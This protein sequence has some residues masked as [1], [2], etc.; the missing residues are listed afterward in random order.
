MGAIAF[1]DAEKADIHSAIADWGAITGITFVDATDSATVSN[2]ADLVF[3]KL[4]FDNWAPINSTVQAT[5]AGFAFLPS[6]S[7]DY[8]IGDVFPDND[9]GNP[10]KQV[11]S[12]EIGHALGLSHPHDGGESLTPVPDPNPH[13]YDGGGHLENYN[14]IMSYGNRLDFMP[15]SPM[16][17]DLDATSALYGDN[18]SANAGNTAYV[19]NVDT[20]N[21]IGN[22]NLR[23][24]IMTP[25]VP[26]I[27]SRLIQRQLRTHPRHICK[28]EFRIVFQLRRCDCDQRC[29]NKAGIRKLLSE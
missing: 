12:H 1:T 22:W 14:T 11:V 16:Q 24:M 3:T 2:P 6:D 28:P 18:S 19:E 26:A 13:V 4:D 25:T 10:F 23:K 7:D 21:P 20:Y 29:D 15:V 17:L 8:I 9:F 27:A 5:S